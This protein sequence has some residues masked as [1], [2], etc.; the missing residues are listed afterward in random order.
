MSRYPN[1]ANYIGAV[2]HTGTT[3]WTDF[4]SASFY[5]Q[6]APDGA[7]SLENVPA[8]KYFS[9]VQVDASAAASDV[10]LKLSA[11]LAA[12]DATNV[13]IRIPAG[14]VLVRGLRGLVDADKSGGVYTIAV[15]LSGADTVYLSANF[16][17]RG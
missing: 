2:I 11:R 9:W 1:D 7:G 12:G 4:T 10:Y 3:D 8:S 15:K 13:A 6:T 14:S 5:D 17:D 16:D